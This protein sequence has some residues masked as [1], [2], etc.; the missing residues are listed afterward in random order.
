[1][2]MAEVSRSIPKVYL[3]YASN[4]ARTA[5]EV[6]HL[7]AQ[8]GGVVTDWGPVA[9]IS[10]IAPTRDTSDKVATAA[11]LIWT[12]WAAKS[13]QV[14]VEVSRAAELKF[15]LFVLDVEGVP[16]EHL[17][18]P[19]FAFEI[20]K[21][22][23]TRDR[24]DV[25]QEMMAKIHRLTVEERTPSKES[26][27]RRK[28]PARK[29]P[30][31][32]SPT[33]GAPSATTQAPL[34]QVPA[35]AA[36]L[37]P[38]PISLLSDTPLS[39]D[40]EDRLDFVVYANALAG[41]VDSQKTTTPLTVVVNAPWG[42]GK[43]SLARL[44]E[45]RLV[46]KPAAGA[47]APHFVHWFNA[48]LHVD[49]PDLG[50]ALAASVA[51]SLNRRRSLLSR[52]FA[53]LSG[54]L[55]PRRVQW[56]W[57]AAF[58]CMVLL[59]PVAWHT[60]AIRVWLTDVVKQY[61]FQCKPGAS[62]SN[63]KW[64][65]DNGWAIALVPLVIVGRFALPIFKVANELSA[66]VVNKR[67]Q[68]AFGTLQDVNGEIGSLL[69]RAKPDANRLVIFIDDLD[70]C[71]P[72]QVVKLLEAMNLLLS[73]PG[74]VIFILADVAAVAAFAQ[75]SFKRVAEVYDPGSQEWNAD[76]QVNGLGFGQLF[77]QKMIQLQFDLPVLKL[78]MS[79]L[80]PSTSDGGKGTPSPQPVVDELGVINQKLASNKTFRR[81]SW[82]M[83]YGALLCL[84]FVQI[85]SKS[86]GYE[87]FWVV[88]KAAQVLGVV[89][90]LSAL[91]VVPL[92]FAIVTV[93]SAIVTVLSDMVWA[94][95]FTHRIYLNYRAGKLMGNLRK[96]L[97]EE[98][99][100]EGRAAE[101]VQAAPTGAIAP[102][103]HSLLQSALQ[104]R[105]E[106]SEKEFVEAAEKTAFAYLS[107]TP[108]S[109]KRVVNRVRL[110]IYIAWLKGL[111]R[112]DPPLTAAHIGKWVALH[113]RWPGIAAKTTRNPRLFEPLKSALLKKGKAKKSV[114]DI[115]AR[116]QDDQVLRRWFSEQP[117]MAEVLKY[118]AEYDTGDDAPA[119]KRSGATAAPA[120][121]GPRFRR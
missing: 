21:F 42:A 72:E 75:I 80:V 18:V 38:G 64:L 24:S 23:G 81:R 79:R 107:G 98:V 101:L 31:A 83:T 87:Y 20:L 28:A 70:R 71:S 104:T 12:E 60:E 84:I 1:M 92:L 63:S 106:G 51:M 36:N 17:P 26:T 66:L 39:R 67:S 57:I 99:T 8:Q 16:L 113:E 11:C 29:A 30:R 6:A 95:V 53:P 93:L 102:I 68:S 43:T 119:R 34:Q 121:A 14:L 25:I 7:I 2:A 103:Y 94:A 74:I 13:H 62:C 114:R 105:A 108:R 10:K 50:V 5:V 44:I 115:I 59:F 89:T 4:D 120:A 86:L 88:Q 22:D 100:K 40:D 15:P 78:K 118:L 32:P 69:R 97:D 55:L 9:S 116:H 52:F 117:D 49:A 45:R 46:A 27:Q 3:V 73:H 110:M 61:V 111:D 65:I 37:P 47:S 35:P 41:V 33:Q 76:G 90:V 91:G 48:W 96:A 54:Q 19:S 109:V 82:R 77:V 112:A 56:G 85:V 58:A